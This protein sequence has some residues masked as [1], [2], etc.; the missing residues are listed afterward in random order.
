MLAWPVQ[1]MGRL[2]PLSRGIQLAD[3]N[4]VARPARFLSDEN[5]ERL[6][7]LRAQHD[8]EGR[9]LSYLTAE[10]VT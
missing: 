3:E 4:L 6:E 2:E 7:S 1:Q 8:P 9:F 10:G 5:A